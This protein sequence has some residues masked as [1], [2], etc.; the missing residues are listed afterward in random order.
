MSNPD[1]EAFLARVLAKI[2]EIPRT[3]FGRVSW[4]YEDR[5]TTEGV[6]VKSGI[7]LDVDT[8]VARIMDVMDY[9]ENVKF[10]QSCTILDQPSPSEITYIQR[11]KLPAIGGIQV[12][13][14]LEDLGERDG[15]RVVAWNQD[16]EQTQALN[17][18]Q[19]GARTAYNL[20]AWLIKPTELAY[21]LSAAPIKK[22]VGS[23]KYTLMIKGSEATATTALSS[24]IDALIAWSQR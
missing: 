18:K 17:P 11:M 4:R 6:G 21:A 16:D 9:P 1:A 5:P 13:L 10:V 23:I 12:A 22:D 2:D 19:G 8:V 14:H 24:N 15:Y 7:E 20:G 3:G